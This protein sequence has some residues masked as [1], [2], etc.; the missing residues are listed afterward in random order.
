M[1][2]DI[3]ENMDDVFESMREDSTH[4]LDLMDAEAAIAAYQVASPEAKH[5][6]ELMVIGQHQ[7]DVEQ[8]VQ[9]MELFAKA[10]MLGDYITSLLVHRLGLMHEVRPEGD[11]KDEAL[12]EEIAVNKPQWGYRKV[13]VTA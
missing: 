13:E 5:L 6:V 11:L 1:S 2:K 12:R 8:A 7:D 10:G 3:W 9:V 4:P